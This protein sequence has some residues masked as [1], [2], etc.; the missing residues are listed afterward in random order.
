MPI[1]MEATTMEVN[2]SHTDAVQAIVD[3][4]I[5]SIAQRGKR[6]AK[7][8]DAKGI[9]PPLVAKTTVSHAVSNCRHDD[10]RHDD[11]RGAK[12]E[13][14]HENKRDC[15]IHKPCQQTYK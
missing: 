13:F 4:P 2:V 15:K 6:T 3:L 10:H 8:M 9:I 12:K 5:A 7:T 1:E 14:S 11:R